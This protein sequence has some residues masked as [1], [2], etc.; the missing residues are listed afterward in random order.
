[1]E[2]V[3][4]IDAQGVYR[5][6]K[7]G[8]MSAKFGATGPKGTISKWS[9]VKRRSFEREI[10]GAQESITAIAAKYEV[11]KQQAYDWK[12]RVLVPAV[13]AAQQVRQIESMNTAREYLDWVGTEIQDSIGAVKR[14]K[15]VTDED[16]NQSLEMADPKRHGTAASLFGQALNHV[17]MLGELTGEFRAAE[18]AQGNSAQPTIIRVITMPKSTD[19][20]GVEVTIPQPRQ[21]L[22]LNPVVE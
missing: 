8:L 2:K 21:P 6:A 10:L 18:E 12:R 19:Q 7:K 20:V 11:S 4:A 9:A 17:K 5:E 1:M 16:G 22:T 14:G 13:S 3:A 15:V